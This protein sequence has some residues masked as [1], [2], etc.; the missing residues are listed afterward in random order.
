[1]KSRIMKKA[2]KNCICTLRLKKSGRRL[3]TPNKNNPLGL[4]LWLKATFKVMSRGYY[5][6]GDYESL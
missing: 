1:M 4:L 5:F 6:L 2:K 3:E